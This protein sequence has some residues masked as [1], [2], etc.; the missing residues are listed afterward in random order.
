MLIFETA[1]N[2]RLAPRSIAAQTL[3]RRR[4]LAEEDRPWTE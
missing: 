4:K 2:A 1:L 3:I